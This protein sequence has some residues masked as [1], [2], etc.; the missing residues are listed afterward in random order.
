V[1]TRN[2]FSF[3]DSDRSRSAHA[4]LELLSANLPVD[5]KRIP[6]GLIEVDTYPPDEL[7]DRLVYNSLTAEST[8]HVVT[9]NAQFYV[10]A[11]RL[12]RFRKCLD[13]AEYICADGFSIQLACKWLS[14][15]AIVR[16]PGVDLVRD[17]CKEG[18]SHGLRVYL[19]GGTPGSAAS[20]AR[21]LSDCYPGLEVV[22]TDCPPLHFEKHPETLNAVLSRLAN[23]RPQVVFVGLGA[24]KQEYFIDQHIRPLRISVAV[25]VGGTFE[26]ISGRVPRAPSWIRRIGMEWC[27]RLLREPRRLWRRYL[28]GNLEFLF[29]IFF[30]YLLGGDPEQ[31]PCS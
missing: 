19:L 18:A 11:E 5:K 25:G 15:T 16:C 14:K 10:M 8:R 1:A 31:E 3:S 28:I 7:T 27:Y 21:I 30:R 24:P 29:I 4:S 26:M 9:A 12:R 2:K 23:A 22:G 6:I 17:L 20:S 13:R